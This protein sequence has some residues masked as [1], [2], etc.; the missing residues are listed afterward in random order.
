M[1]KKKE[2]KKA[3]VKK[4]KP[5]EKKPA[6]KKAEEKAAKPAKAATKPEKPASPPVKPSATPAE[7]LAEAAAVQK[8]MGGKLAEKPAAVDIS[9]P[10]VPEEPPM[11]WVSEKVGAALSESS[12]RPGSRQRE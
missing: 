12:D 6:E 2:A 3:E 5:E 10:D 4:D 11:R 7:I 8:A 1:L 9:E